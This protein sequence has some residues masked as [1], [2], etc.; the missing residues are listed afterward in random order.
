MVRHTPF[1]NSS[2]IKMDDVWGYGKQ[3]KQDKWWFDLEDVDG[4][5][6]IPAGVNE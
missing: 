6:G 5:I 3:N 4:V 1:M 2:I